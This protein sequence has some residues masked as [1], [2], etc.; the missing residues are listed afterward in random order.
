MCFAREE[1]SSEDHGN[2]KECDDAVE[3]LAVELDVAINS[4]S[5]AVER[6]K[7]LNDR[8]DEHG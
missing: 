7:A 4:F 1:E 6:I 5:V 2:R 8:C 3:C